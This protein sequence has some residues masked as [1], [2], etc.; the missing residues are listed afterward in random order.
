VCWDT[1]QLL[2]HL[3]SR[4]GWPA[5]GANATGGGER[6]R[7][8][9]LAAGAVELRAGLAG[10]VWKGAEVGPPPQQVIDLA[11]DLSGGGQVGQREVGPGQLPPGLDRI[12]R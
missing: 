6:C 11:Q 10:L 8:D 2:A 3:E 5:A 7:P 9:D 1:Y 12:V 4:G